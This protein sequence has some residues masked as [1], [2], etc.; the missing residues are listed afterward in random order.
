MARS[1]A[2]RDALSDLEA[3]VYPCVAFESRMQVLTLYQSTLLTWRFGQ[4][5]WMVGLR[6]LAMMYPSV[7]MLTCLIFS[8]SMPLSSAL[9]S[10]QA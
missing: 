10:A 6:Q 7:A 2:H 4:A 1:Y 5:L 9:S 3:M 8:N